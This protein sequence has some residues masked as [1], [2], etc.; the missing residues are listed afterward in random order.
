MEPAAFITT[1]NPEKNSSWFHGIPRD[2]LEQIS[3]TL[4]IPL[5]LIETSGE[6]YTDNFEA[7]LR[8]ARGMG[9]EA[10]VFGDIDIP[11][12]REWCTRRCENTGLEAVFPLWGMGRAEVVGEVIRLGFTADITIVNTGK[13]SERFLGLRLDSE[14][15]GQIAAEGADICGENGEYHTFVSGGPIF[16]APLR[17]MLGGKVADGNYVRLPVGGVGSIIDR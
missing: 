14:T 3:E 12:H 5:W 11:E 9:V 13:L 6:A 10:C 4:G 8:G 16:K 15:A 17:V 1:F 2:V 7:T